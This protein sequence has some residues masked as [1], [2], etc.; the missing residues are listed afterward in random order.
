MNDLDFELALKNNDTEL[1]AKIPKV[2][3]HNHVVSSCKKSYLIDCGIN[4]SKDKINNIE[5]LIN[6]SRSYLDPIKKDYNGLKL[7][8]EGTFENCLQTGVVLVFASIDYK[9]CM[10]TFNSNVNTFIKFLKS[11]KYNNLTILWDLSISRDSYKEENKSLILKLLNTRFFSGIDLAATEN[12]IPN[13]NFVDF[14]KLANKLKMITR[15]HAGEQLGAEYIKECI[16]DF[17]P[18]QIQHGIHIV[19][20]ESVM[21]LAKEKGIVFNVC[22]TSNIVLGYAT[23][24]KD[25]PIKKM[26]EFGLN[27]TIATDDLLFFDSDINEEYL[28]LYK[29]G[30]LTSKQLNR[31]RNFSLSLLNEEKQSDSTYWYC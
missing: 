5:T 6:F 2:D 3:I 10:R 25:H 14:Y 16:N 29:E 21:Q 22:P 18:K 13:L 27:V 9:E 28:K 23:S 12:S 15:V 20:D 4:L 11:F 7:L 24:I 30:T 17:N 31:I 19:E 26:V 1:L 8:L